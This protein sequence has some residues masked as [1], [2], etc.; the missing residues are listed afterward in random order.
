VNLKVPRLFT[1]L[2]W[3]LFKRRLPRGS[4]FLNN[5]DAYDALEMGLKHKSCAACI[6]SGVILFLNGKRTKGRGRLSEEKNAFKGKKL[7]ERG[8]EGEAGASLL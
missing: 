5:R 3:G 1:R 6:D 2:G 4:Q 8:D 7:V